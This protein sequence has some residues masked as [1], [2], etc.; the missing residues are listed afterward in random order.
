[1]SKR[2]FL[3]IL[4][5]WGLGPK[6]EADAIF[7]AD[8]PFMDQLMKQYPMSTLVTHGEEVGLPD[9]QMGNSEV[10]HLNIGAGRVV[11]QE[12]AR[13]NK[14]VR[15]GELHQ[16]RV[17]LD[18]LDHARENGKA[19][20]FL[21]LVSDGGVHSHIDHLKALCDIAVERGCPRSYVHAF[22][23]GRDCDPK[24]GAGFLED[25]MQHIEGKPVA[26]A[27]VIGRYYA[28]DRD[29]R[30]ERIKLAYDL[31]V[32]GQGEQVPA[33][34][35]L[36]AIHRS[37][38]E[39]VTDE[40]LKPIL[41]LNDNASAHI[42]PGD[43]V[44][45]FNFRTDRCR[46][47]TQVLT[48]MDMHEYNMHTLPLY[49]V[50]MT[51]YDDTYKGVKVMYEKD[52]VRLTMGEVLANAGKTQVRIA[53]TEKYPHVTFFFSGGRE[54]PFEGE[55]RIMCPSP[56][57]A[58]YDLQPEMSALDITDAIMKDI[59]EH[60]PDFICLN[61]AN[62]D[63]VGHTGVF[64]AAMKAAETVDG[65]LSRIIPLA[66]EYD[67][68][69]LLIADHGNSDYMINEDGTPNT[70]HTKNPVPC[71]LVSKRLSGSEK[72]RNG[73]LADVAPTL[74]SR[75]EIEKPE[76]MTGKNLVEG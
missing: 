51:R 61:F 27:S 67:Y 75:M 62:T 55:R 14:A 16:N 9:G 59:R 69:C 38:D 4:D 22:T 60:Q 23:D 6:P 72:L 10:G 76:V 39:G 71:I 12:L 54:E 52:D 58:T 36:A 17:L 63:M 31:L 50:T 65:C 28:M 53:E 13:I 15:D 37:Y 44:I 5:G 66:L 32:N 26:L 70:A 24:S 74:L 7:Q 57:V 25:L 20:H 48:Q 35:L 42:E 3:L 47:I 21:G 45:C 30:W 18:A 19:V 73:R 43:V 41:V 40:F 2:A 1:M 68:D 29:K 11:W 33:G 34:K 8:T 56:K 64:A 46:E 49:Y